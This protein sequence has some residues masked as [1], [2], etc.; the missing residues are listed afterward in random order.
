MLQCVILTY[1]FT[2]LLTYLLT[3]SMKQS[4]SW[5]ANN[6][7]ASQ[8]FPIL[9]NQKVHYNIHKCL[10]PVPILRQL[11]PVHNPTF[12]FL[13][14]HLNIIIP[15]M[16]GSPKWSLSFRLPHQNPV[17]AFPLPLTCYMLCPS[18]SYQFYHPND[19]GWGVHI[20]KLLIT[21]FSPLPCHLVPIRP[22]YTQHPILEHSQP[23]FLLPCEWQNFTPIQNNTQ[24]YSSVHL[25]L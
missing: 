16:P 13:Q 19:I 22:K 8:E 15:S 6:L 25:N 5:E 17:Q 1:L 2:Y 24:N 9:W 21:Q 14:I 10:P 23:T 11:D 4:P 7:S 18:H 3:Y 12:H 20:I